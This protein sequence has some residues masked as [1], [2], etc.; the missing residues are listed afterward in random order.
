VDS[1]GD[2]AA[3]ED[4]SVI[5]IRAPHER[6]TSPLALPDVPSLAIPFYELQQRAE[7][8][9][10]DRRYLLY[11]DQG[12]MSRMQALHLHDRGLTHFGIYRDASRR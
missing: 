5:D 4:V 8:L 10:G 11:C 2:L 1:P 7:E 6:E 3:A 9:P 12:I